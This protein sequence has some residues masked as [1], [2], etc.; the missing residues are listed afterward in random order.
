MK[1]L[2]WLTR[3]CVPVVPLKYKRLVRCSP[4]TVRHGRLTVMGGK[5]AA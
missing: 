4:S 3:T 2:K 5:A 1:S